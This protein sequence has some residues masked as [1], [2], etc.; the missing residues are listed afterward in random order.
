MRFA[1]PHLH[2]TTRPPSS[3]GRRTRGK[4]GGE[5]E[6]VGA[7]G[8]DGDGVFEVDGGFAV[9]CDDG[10]MV[11]GDADIFFAGVDHGLD[12]EDHADLESEVFLGVVEVLVVGDLRFFVHFAADAVADEVFDEREAGGVDELFHFGGDFKPFLAGLN[13]V[14]GGHEDGFADFEKLFR[15]RADLSDRVG[16]GGIATPAVEFAAGVDADDVSFAENTLA[17]DAVDD[18]FVDRDAG[19]GGKRDFSRITFEERS[20]FVS[21]EESFEFVFDL[22]C[23]DAGLAHGSGDSMGFGNQLAGQSHLFNFSTAL[24]LNHVVDQG[25]SE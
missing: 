3:G 11:F 21:G 16:P 10:P 22:D 7:G 14:D 5:G 23:L 4:L 24:Q 1:K 8:G 17:W 15:L 6:D 2:P 18:F 9:E 12:G 20:G 25:T 19:H 13:L